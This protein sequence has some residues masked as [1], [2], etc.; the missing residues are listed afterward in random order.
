MP[1]VGA[2]FVLP[3]FS[4][5]M[6]ASLICSG[7]SKS[8]SPAAKPQTSSPAAWRALAFASTASVGEGE[9]LRAQVESGAGGLLMDKRV[10]QRT[11]FQE[12]QARRNRATKRVR[13]MYPS[14]GP[15]ARGKKKRR[16]EDRR[17]EIGRD[18]L[19]FSFC[20][21]PWWAALRGRAAT[22]R[23]RWRPSVARNASAS[24]ADQP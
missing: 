13:G 10:D 20:R 4:A 1:G 17:L 3:A 7:V 2:Y 11:A 12:R 24:S 8:G 15:L 9:T 19:T 16:S 18:A 5:A 21:C 6:H 22:A 14:R 23:R